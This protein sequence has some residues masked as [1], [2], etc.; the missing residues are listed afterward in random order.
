MSYH[1]G[2]FDLR[3]N[4]QIVGTNPNA[5]GFDATA[6]D[7]AGVPALIGGRPDM[8]FQALQGGIAEMMAF[9]GSLSD[10]ELAGVEQYLM[11]RYGL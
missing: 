10:P 8:N 7:A 9:K 1:G 4:G 3:I 2:T 6:F 5:S 11:T